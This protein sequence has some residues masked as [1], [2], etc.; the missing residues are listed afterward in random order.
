LSEK[1]KIVAVAHASNVLGTVNPVK[2]RASI[3]AFPLL[4]FLCLHSLIISLYV[5]LSL[6][7]YLLFSVG[8]HRG[9][10]REGGGGAP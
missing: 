1:T 9:G 8:D 6:F 7:I 3:D 4:F 10:A 2:V 5:F